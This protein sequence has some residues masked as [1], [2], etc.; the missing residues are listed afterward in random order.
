MIQ[1]VEGGGI[2]V[3]LPGQDR[4]KMVRLLDTSELGARA[5]WNNHQM[6]SI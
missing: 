2:S 5:H 6:M 4:K 3:L 1:D